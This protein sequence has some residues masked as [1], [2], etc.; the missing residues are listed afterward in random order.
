ML[1][2]LYETSDDEGDYKYIIRA[3]CDTIKIENPHK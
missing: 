1:V 3:S 2:K